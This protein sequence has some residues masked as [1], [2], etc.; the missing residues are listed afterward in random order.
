MAPKFSFA[1]SLPILMQISPKIAE[2]LKIDWFPQFN[3][4]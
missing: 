4:L 2:L 1:L 3:M